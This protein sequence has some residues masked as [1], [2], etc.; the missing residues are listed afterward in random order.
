M[1]II[2]G[3]TCIGDDGGTAL[4]KCSKCEAEKAMTSRDPKQMAAERWYVLADFMFA[5]DAPSWL[6]CE[7]C[8]SERGTNVRL[9]IPS[10]VHEKDCKFMGVTSALLYAAALADDYAKL[11]A[12][13]ARLNISLE[14]ASTELHGV[15]LMYSEA[16]SS[17]E[18]AEQRIA[19]LTAQHNA[20]LQRDHAA[21]IVF[22][23]R[24][25]RLVAALK[26]EA[27]RWRE[28]SGIFNHLGRKFESCRTNDYA[29]EIDALLT[30]PPET[31]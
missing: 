2:D 22:T 29:N 6:D 21:L 10:R 9:R 3:H 11:E 15:K 7:V 23:A 8:R 27:F 12:E 14:E 13:N 5:S 31:P 1:S 19:A 28:V 24:E 20:D 16:V 18:A 25:A 17:N 26:D 30:S 4:R